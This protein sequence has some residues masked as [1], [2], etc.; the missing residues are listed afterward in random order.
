MNETKKVAMVSLG[1]PKN[2]VDGEIMLADLKTNGFEITV[3][4]DEADIIIINTCGFIEDAKRE[5]IENILEMSDY[6][7]YGCLKALIVTG[8]LAERY[9]DELKSEMPEVDVVVG[10]GSN[11]NIA[12]LC[13]DA[14]NNNMHNCYGDKSDLPLNGNR[15]LSTP[16]YTAYLKIADGCNNRCTYCAIPLIRGD[17]RSRKIEDILDEANLLANQGVKELV[18]IAQDTTYYGKDIYGKLM[19]PE[20]LKE[21]NKIDKIEWIRVLY[22]YP[23]F[24]TDEL[25]QTIKNTEKVVKYLD[26]PLQHANEN[27]LKNMNRRGNLESLKALVSKLKEEIPEIVLRTTFI[28]GFP[29]ETNED[30]AELCDFVKFAK[31][32]RM[33]AF[34]Y[35]QEEGTIAA[36]MEDQIDEEI[37]AR[38]AEV[39]M[40]IQQS[41]S[42]ELLTGYTGTTQT[43][44]VEG[45]DG[46]CK[47]YFG[48]RK[49]DAPEIDGKVFFSSDFKPSNGDFVKV[50]IENSLEYD[51]FGKQV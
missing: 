46:Y 44:L 20:L 45:Y 10:I 28:V 17:Y 11:K 24:I 42:E 51:L 33:G 48:R 14:L 43:V 40:D 34:P 19:L 16:P 21:L 50:L 15:I 35:S 30:F 2:Q 37:K 9:R 22:A 36:E 12:K 25:I 32:E 29:G 31:F 18:V 3:K 6:K 39:I 8:C 1:C 7:Q 38:R 5:S 47:K 4:A 41:V 23:D 13:N 26:I 49:G 27:V